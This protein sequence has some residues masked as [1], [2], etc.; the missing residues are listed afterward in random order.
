MRHDWKH[1]LRLKTSSLIFI[2]HSTSHFFR[3]VCYFLYA[4]VPCRWVGRGGPTAWFFLQ[5]Y[6]KDSLSEGDS[7]KVTAAQAGP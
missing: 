3:M 4:H 1:Y 7:P 6:L 5:N 2:R